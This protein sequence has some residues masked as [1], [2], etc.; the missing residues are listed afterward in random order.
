MAGTGTTGQLEADL[1]AGGRRLL[2]SI[3]IGA[4]PSPAAA[5]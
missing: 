2:G 3:W 1:P 5:L 4:L